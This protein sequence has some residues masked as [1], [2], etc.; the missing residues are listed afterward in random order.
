MWCGLIGSYATLKRLSGVALQMV[1]LKRFGWCQ[2]EGKV[3][4]F[5]LSVNSIVFSAI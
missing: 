5:A 1:Y 3:T 2:K 4:S